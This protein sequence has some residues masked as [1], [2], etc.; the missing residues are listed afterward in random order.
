MIE[1]LLY[2]SEGPQRELFNF[3][4]MRTLEA[5]SLLDDSTKIIS[6]KIVAWDRDDYLGEDIIKKLHTIEKFNRFFINNRRYYL[7]D[8]ELTLQDHME[9]HSHD[10]GEVAIYM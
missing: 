6:A 4:E 1:C 10:D 5:T 3:S 7:N 9:I 2:D 8:C